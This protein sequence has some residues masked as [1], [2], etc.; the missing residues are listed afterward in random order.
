[1]THPSS[2]PPLYLGNEAD[3]QTQL[4]AEIVKT[5]GFAITQQIPQEM[6]L[7]LTQGTLGLKDNRFPRDNPVIVDFASD[8][9]TYRRKH[10]GGKR[11]IIARAIGVKSQ[12]P[13]SVVDATGGL[14]RD[15]LVLASLGCQ[16]TLLE[17]SPVVAA[18]LENGL[19]RAGTHPAT[20]AW[21]PNRLQLKFGDS[22]QL[23]GQWQGPPP[24]VVY[25][26]PM[27]PHKKKTALVKKEMRA[28]Q[29]LLG[30][31]CDTDELI[32]VALRCAAKRVVVKRPAYAEHL[33]TIAP[34]ASIYSKKHRFDLYLED[35]LLQS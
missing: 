6:Y 7:S 16:V 14:G 22:R 13:P 21:V 11:E 4:V 34:S 24:D 27:F 17:R 35:S 23:L 9:L 19:L 1:M 20:S 3:N 31:D 30:G 28:L 25:L 29:A 18:L 12:T 8:T 32:A 2:T 5:W 26:D 15:A 10:G 33:G